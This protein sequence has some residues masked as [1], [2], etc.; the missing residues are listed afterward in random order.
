MPNSH[1]NMSFGPS[2]GQSI[3][4]AVVLS[5]FGLA[6]AIAYSLGSPEEA[7]FWAGGIAFPV[8]AWAI[9]LHQYIFS[10]P[11][12]HLLTHIKGFLIRSISSLFYLVLFFGLFFFSDSSIINKATYMTVLSSLSLLWAF[13]LYRRI[14][15]IEDTQYTRLNSAAQ[16]YAVLEGKVSLHDGEVARGPNA[17]LPVMV[18]FRKY[19][20]T[21]SAGF[22]LDDGYGLCTIDPVDAEVITPRHHYTSYAYYAVYPGE[23]V[24]VI[25]QLKTLSKQRNERERKAL[26]S[27]KI[28]EWKRNR[29]NFLK[30]FDKNNDGVVDDAEMVAVRN[31]ADRVVE[32]NLEESYQQPASHVISRAND[33]RPFILSSIRPD[34]L[35][36]RYKYAMFFH[37]SAWI[38][39][40]LFSYAM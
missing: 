37:F 8:F 36:K 31:V 1:T 34:K 12:S 35:I 29:V 26:V 15:L 32:H 30:Y 7:L 38:M 3:V 22:L 2:E 23:T 5:V 28:I 40:A 27:S 16:G 21:S 19:L 11:I 18:W 9:G 33:G 4:W 13:L 10:T 17:Q 20:Y 39:L 24:Y 25:G 6:G 14:R